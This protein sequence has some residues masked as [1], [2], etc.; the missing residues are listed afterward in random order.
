[1]MTEVTA[2]WE[3]AKA[4]ALAE[5]FLK[6]GVKCLKVKTGLDPAGDVA[7]VKAVLDGRRE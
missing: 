5:R 7:R 1:M 2:G 4:V 3:V 6:G